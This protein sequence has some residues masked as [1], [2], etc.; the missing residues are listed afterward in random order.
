MNSAY[1]YTEHETRLHH[2]VGYSIRRIDWGA[3]FNLHIHWQSSD[4]LSL[5][6]SASI[7][8]RNAIGPVKSCRVCCKIKTSLFAIKSMSAC[9]WRTNRVFVL[10]TSEWVQCFKMVGAM[11]SVICIK[12]ISL[13]QYACDDIIRVWTYTPY[14]V[15]TLFDRLQTNGLVFELKISSRDYNLR[16]VDRCWFSTTT[17]YT[18]RQ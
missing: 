9:K 7:V 16:D 17:A 13:M 6:H 5:S 15:T 11:E 3:Y 12:C 4:W 1:H 2:D 10:Y 14:V 18:I 8:C